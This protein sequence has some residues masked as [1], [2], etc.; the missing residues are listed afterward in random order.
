MMIEIT[1]GDITQAPTQAIVNAANEQ[2]LLGSGVA[3]AILRTGGSAIQEEC[4]PLAPIREGEAVVTDAGNLRHDYVIHAV[5]PNGTKPGWENL[6]SNCASNI[7]RICEENHIESV[8]IPALGTGV[9]NLP[10]SRVAELL[11][12]AAQKFR[13]EHLQKI[14]FVLFDEENF[15]WFHRANS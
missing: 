2:L 9:F 7:F 3:G 4:Y 14:V 15:L 1:Q 12:A 5:A 8:A 10:P 13:G 6:V 11:V